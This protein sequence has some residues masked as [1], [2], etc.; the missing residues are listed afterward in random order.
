MLAV[1]SIGPSRTERQQKCIASWIAAGLEVVAVQPPGEIEKLEP[2]YQGVRFVETDK[3][4]DKFNCPH[5]VRIS[6]LIDQCKDQTGLILNSDLVVSN[7]YPSR[8]TEK[9]GT[10]SIGIRWNAMPN[11]AKKLFKWGVDAFLITPEI[12]ALIPDIGLAMGLP[13]WDYF[14]PWYLAEKCGHKIET[15]KTAELIH[16]QHPQAW[17]KQSYNTGLEILASEYGLSRDAI[18]A[19]I[20]RATGRTHIR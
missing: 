3:V 7:A 4:A 18:A 14:I 5:M 1:T 15:I 13:A 9:Q 20:Q 8:F 17:S 11:G 2:H 10:L 12:S 16:E 19:Y 6:A